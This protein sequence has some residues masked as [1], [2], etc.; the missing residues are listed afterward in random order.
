MNKRAQAAGLANE[1]GIER[2][3]C[4]RQRLRSHRSKIEAGRRRNAQ[5][6]RSSAA[7]SLARLYAERL[8]SDDGYQVIDQRTVTSTFQELLQKAAADPAPIIKEQLA[9]WSD[10]ALLWQSTAAPGPVQCRR[11]NP[12]IEPARQDKRFKSELVDR[13]SLFRLR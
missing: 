5:G 3:T 6:H 8:K 10:L 12:V 11:S 7:R 2:A 9:L 1:A 13:E 4:R